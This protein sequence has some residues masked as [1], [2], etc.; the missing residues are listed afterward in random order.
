MVIQRGAL[1]SFSGHESAGGR[2]DLSFQNRRLNTEIKSDGSWRLDFE[3][4]E[5]GG[6]WDI[7][8]EKTLPGRTERRVIEDVLVGDVYLMSG[9]SN[10]AMDIASVY[11]SFCQDIE[12]FSSDYVRQFK[13]NTA[14]DYQQVHTDTDDGNWVRAQ[15]VDKRSFGAIGFF[16]AARLY[17]EH[18][19]PIGLIQTAVPGCPI[20]SFLNADNYLRFYPEGPELP[21]ACRSRAD[22]AAQ[23]SAENRAIA[24]FEQSILAKDDDLD[25]GGGTRKWQPCQIPIDLLNGAITDRSAD[26][27]QH[28]GSSANKS[29]GR[30]IQN[31]SGVI[32]F[33]NEIELT[34]D[35]LESSQNNSD[36]SDH[37]AD[38]STAGPEQSDKCSSAID[39]LLELGLIIDNDSTY[40]NGKFIGRTFSQYASRRYKLPAG[41]LKPGKNLIEVR[42]VYMNGICRFWRDQ[43]YRLTTSSRVIDL[44]GNWQM[45]LGHQ[46]DSP[47]PSKV[48]FEYFP[49][50][51]YNAMLAPVMSYPAS[52]LLWYQ[53]ESNAGAPDGYSD[54]L[55][56]L[57]DQIRAEMSLPELP[58]YFVQL[59]DYDSYDD[60]QNGKWQ[61]L[62]N[63]QELAANKIPNAY[64]IVS[65]DVGDITNLHPQ[66]KKTLGERIADLIL[67]AL[68]RA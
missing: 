13:L 33:R 23:T 30:N 63:E 37:S 1:I 49:S 46:E 6:P 7:V 17:R 18:N 53:G 47:F 48:F 41:L 16:M 45:S 44:T 38:D 22:M 9:Q 32:W 61:Q 59:P 34:A 66:D 15:S 4:P 5:V 27:D 20:E 12:S 19:I 11:N 36:L 67:P 28:S 25:A 21:S 62:Q 64:M 54:K 55:A 57:V 60:A 26:A 42:V 29:E 52:A 39:P 51:V 58:V 10:M 43:P 14:Y 56:V 65:R 8:I 24:E 68:A 3:Q 35:D 40:V 31:G 50:G 2:I